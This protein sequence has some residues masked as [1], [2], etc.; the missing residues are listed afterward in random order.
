[1]GISRLNEQIT[2]N[3]TYNGSSYK[4]QSKHDWTNQYYG[5][6]TK[7]KFHA[8]SE[9]NRYY[10]DQLLLT[11]GGSEVKTDVR[12]WYI[13]GGYRVNKWLETGSYYSHYRIFPTG[14]RGTYTDA[15]RHEFDKVITAKFIINQY[16]YI[17]SPIDGIVLE[18][19]IDPGQS[20]TGGSSSTSTSLFTIAGSLTKMQIKA[21]V[22][23]LD[24]SSIKVGQDVR[25]TVEANPGQTFSG[26]VK[27][28]R[29]VPETSDSV[30]YYYVIIL[31]DN[32]SG[33]LLPGMTASVS[34]IKQKKE[35]PRAGRGG[36][37]RVRFSL[38]QFILSFNCLLLIIIS[39]SVSDT[40]GVS[41][42][43]H[44]VSIMQQPVA[45]GISQSGVTYIW[46][47]FFDWA[48]T[49][50]DGRSGLVPVLDYL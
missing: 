41:S 37:A 12:G 21:E 31:A 27:E 38:A 3:G 20:V 14:G 17:T 2:G 8:E 29:L 5:Q 45:D 23:E 24:I 30:V 50:N 42:H 4:E 1:V 6:Y 43:F 15:Q 13:S 16:A 35:E 7:D 49:G 10:R 33:K 19:D 25:F 9:Y 34:F 26:Q 28:I 22:A 32:K 44:L 11:L 36:V 40:H 48:L 18:R 39:Y 46:M 47:P